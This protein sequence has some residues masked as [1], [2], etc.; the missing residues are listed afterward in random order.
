MKGK[1]YQKIS[2]RTR[3]F[4]RPGIA[5]VG[6]IVFMAGLFSLMKT[7]AS[8]SLHS[9]G[10]DGNLVLSSD[11][12]LNRYVK[13]IADASIGDTTVQI[14]DADL[15]DDPAFGDLVMIVQMQ[16]ASINSTN[17]R[18]WGSVSS[19]NNAGNYEFAYI[20]AVDFEANQISF[21]SP[22]TKDYASSGNVQLIKVPEYTDLTINS[23][24]KV[25]SEKWNGITG[26]I[27]VIHASGT[28]TIDG[29]INVDGV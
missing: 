12:V 25:T 18:T 15:L 2:P 7:D 1:F 9:P 8:T 6:C 22:L 24:T 14:M 4:I 21:C 17:D 3:Q 23:G 26:G 28:V 11:S 19:L 29:E 16:G 20:K 5:L 27:V 13:V 10:G